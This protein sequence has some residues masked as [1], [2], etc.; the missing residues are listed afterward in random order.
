MALPGSTLSEA[1]LQIRDFFGR[2]V[3]AGDSLISITIGNPA[4]AIP[5]DSDQNH[6]LNLFFYRFEPNYYMPAAD[7]GE[8][9][10]LRLY[11]LVTAFGIDELAA[12]GVNQVSAGENEMR[13]LGHVLRAAH[14]QPVLDP[15]EVAGERVRLQ[16]VFQP[17]GV[18]E[19]NQIWLTQ[20]EVAY[21]PSVCYQFS[22]VPVPPKFPQRRAERPT[23]LE[24]AARG[25]VDQEARDWR[26]PPPEK[27]S[28][29]GD[30]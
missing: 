7:P 17:L 26:R 20:G 19:I 27:L 22:L 28:G 15:F 4:A 11:C 10:R 1:C 12:D 18:D 21:H 23:H 3:P 29:E 13:L 2:E 30:P 5:H 25:Q 8:T 14:S 6:R 9:W 16:M 24:I